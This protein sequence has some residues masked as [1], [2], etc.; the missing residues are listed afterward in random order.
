MIVMG[1]SYN[2]YYCKHKAIDNVIK[3]YVDDFTIK[4]KMFGKT[5]YYPRFILDDLLKLL[6]H[7]HNIM[8][9]VA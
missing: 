9:V 5:E 7:D 8:S 4:V 2:V 3:L 1:I 6:E